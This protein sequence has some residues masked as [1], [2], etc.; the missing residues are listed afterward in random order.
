MGGERGGRL[1]EWLED[2]D[3]GEGRGGS[4]MLGCVTVRC[5]VDEEEE[6]ETTTP[7]V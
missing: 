5:D 6:D 3:G 7:I 2:G 1:G 4:E